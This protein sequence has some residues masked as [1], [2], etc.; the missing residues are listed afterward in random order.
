MTISRT[1][2]AASLLPA[3]IRNLGT[4]LADPAMIE[5]GVNLSLQWGDAFVA[6]AKELDDADRDA[7][8][9]SYVKNL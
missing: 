2:V 6:K 5:Y 8:T 3:I 4:T 1:E 7:A 9:D